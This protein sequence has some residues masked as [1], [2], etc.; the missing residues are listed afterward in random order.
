MVKDTPD[1]VQRWKIKAHAHMIC[2]GIGHNESTG[3]MFT[4]V[5]ASRVSSTTC[6]SALVQ[7]SSPCF[8]RS[9]IHVLK[10]RPASECQREMNSSTQDQA[11]LQ[12]STEYKTNVCLR[13]HHDMLDNIA[14]PSLTGVRSASTAQRAAVKHFRLRSIEILTLAMLSEILSTS[15]VEI[16]D[17]S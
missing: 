11:R 10:K 9:R 7:C 6:F 2:V 16:A 14:I 8:N 13:C 5:K 12:H 3:L 15:W 4:S 1:P 17:R